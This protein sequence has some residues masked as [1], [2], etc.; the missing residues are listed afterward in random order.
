MNKNVYLIGSNTEQNLAKA[1]VGESQARNRYL[2]YAGVAKK[3]GYPTLERIFLETA[4]NERGHAEM[5]FEYLTN[6]LPKRTLQPQ[7][8]VPAFLGDTAQNLL[9]AAEGEREE[10]S[11]LYPAFGREAES[12]GFRQIAESFYRI[13]SIEKTH[14][15]RYSHLLNRLKTGTMFRLPGETTWICTNCGLHIQGKGAPEKCPACLHAKSYFM[16]YNDEI[17]PLA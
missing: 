9:A 7:V 6:E 1:F 2:F 17:F 12:E 11:K 4:D 10:W 16:A 5:F 3:E 13:A 15:E 8:A 14:D